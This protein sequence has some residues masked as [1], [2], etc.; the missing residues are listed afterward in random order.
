[1]ESWRKREKKYNQ[2]MDCCG[3][4]QREWE[5]DKRGREKGKKKKL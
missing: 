1:M 4:K 3:E 2:S 5:E